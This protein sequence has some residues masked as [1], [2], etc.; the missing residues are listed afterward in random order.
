[1]FYHL[2]NMVY[3]NDI[4]TTYWQKQKNMSIELPWFYPVQSSKCKSAKSSKNRLIKPCKAWKA[5]FE[6]LDSHNESP[7]SFFG[8]VSY[9]WEKGTPCKWVPI[10]SIFILEENFSSNMF[11]IFGSLLV[12]FGKCKWLS[13]LIFNLALMRLC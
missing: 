11:Q 8:K 4:K 7:P 6:K 5:C 2:Y 9:A 10:I 1:M 12:F 13:K 3:I